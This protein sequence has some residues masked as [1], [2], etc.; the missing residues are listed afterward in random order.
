LEYE[1]EVQF[2]CSGS[3]AFVSWVDNTLGLRR[4]ANVIWEGA[5]GFEFKILDS[6][7]ELERAIRAK[8][9]AGFKSRV[10]A[11]YCWQWSKPKAD[12]TLVDDVV[13]GDYK[14]PWNAKPDAG[15]LAP[16]IPK[17]NFWADDPNGIDQ[18]GCVYTAQGFEY[19]YSG[20]IF[21]PD[22]KYNFDSQAW[23][24]NPKDSFDPDVKRA[25][26]DMTKLVQSAYR[27]LLSRA[28]KG[29]YVCFVDKDTE[30]F[31]RSRID[32]RH[33]K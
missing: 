28:M 17:S 16:G 1:L 27:V 11:G 18:I 8:A 15:I 32:Q 20:V 9:S 30:R 12:G 25:G 7:E 33:A 31:F 23:E 22:L 26:S 21:G 5:D 6:P 29:C 3:D 2:R 14:R 10:T 4:T 13:I 24:A 19:D